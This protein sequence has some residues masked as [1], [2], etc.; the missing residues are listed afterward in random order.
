MAVEIAID[1]NR[2]R[3]FVDGVPQA[4]AVFRAAAKIHIP[5]IVVVELRAGQGSMDRRTRRSA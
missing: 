4:V 2:Y 5:L 1:T 3:D